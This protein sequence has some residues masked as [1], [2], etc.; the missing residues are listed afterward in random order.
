MTFAWCIAL[1]GQRVALQVEEVAASGVSPR[2]AA[3]LRL[4]LRS[5]QGQQWEVLVNADQQL[6]H[7]NQAAN[8]QQLRVQKIK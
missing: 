2:K 7:E 4:K 8:A 5:A 1:D 3:V 6:V